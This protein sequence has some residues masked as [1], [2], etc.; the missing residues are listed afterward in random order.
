MRIRTAFVFIMIIL[1]TACK[2]RP[3]KFTVNGELTNSAGKTIY[4]QEMTTFD[5]R[6]VDSMVINESGEFSLTG[7]GSFERFYALMSGKDDYITLI[8][9]PGD[10][11]KVTADYENLEK[12]YTVEG[13]ED[14]RQVRI[15]TSELNRNLEKIKK[16]RQVFQDSLN[17]PGFLKTKERLDAKYMEIAQN[18]R[19]F[20]IDF[21]K[22]NLNSLASLMALYQQVGPNMSVLDPDEDMKYYH[23]VDSSLS[24][25]YPQYDAVEHLHRQILDLKDRRKYM[26]LAASQLKP[27]STAPEIALPDPEGDTILLSSL[28][29]NYVLLDFWASWCEP[30]RKEHP[31]LVKAYNK[32]HKKGLEI[33]QVSLDKSREPWIKAIKNDRL[34]WIHVSDLKFWESVVV[35]VYN[36]KGIPANFLLDKE[37]KVIASNLRGEQLN[38]TLKE[39][40][41]P[42]KP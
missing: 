26:E 3:R 37:G 12:T 36:L 22:R 19:K 23:M 10:K 8:L 2:N 14:C 24:E 7:K 9:G 15:L 27:G 25:I 41:H 28:R 4:L 11:V 38:K 18:Q 32:Y 35:P 34:D 33:Y 6:H 5:L 31:N 13:S 21:I 29:G 20:T 39:I 42:D 17:E 1:V 40:F 16:L 30:C